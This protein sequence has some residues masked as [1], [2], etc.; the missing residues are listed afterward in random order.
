MALMILAVYLFECEEQYEVAPTIFFA[1]DVHVQLKKHTEYSKKYTHKCAN[2]G[3]R[4][5]SIVGN[6]WLMH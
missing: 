1:I 5:R 6:L 3:A 2:G 4:A